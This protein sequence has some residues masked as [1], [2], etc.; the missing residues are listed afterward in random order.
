MSYV[1]NTPAQ[2]ED[3]LRAMNRSSIEELLTSI[4]K[5]VRLNR[6]LSLPGAKTE[7]E[8]IDELT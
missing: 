3:M 4:P 8:V 1:P 2:R 7:F 5:S 6:A